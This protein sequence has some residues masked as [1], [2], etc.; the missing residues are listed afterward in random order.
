MLVAI[1]EGD[2][3]KVEE[4]EV[5]EVLPD[6]PEKIAEIIARLENEMR[7]AAKKFEFERAAE[8]RDK[9]RELRAKVL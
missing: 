8:L 9:A 3:V 1:S 7:E 4:E 6:D 5:A 2:Y